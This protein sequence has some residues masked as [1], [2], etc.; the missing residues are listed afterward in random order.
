LIST[1]YTVPASLLSASASKKYADRYVLLIGLF[2]Y[3]IGALLKINYTYN[4]FINIG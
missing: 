2:V 1:V 3:L 4:E